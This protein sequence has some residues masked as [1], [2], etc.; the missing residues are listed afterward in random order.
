MPVLIILKE[1]G[2]SDLS[3]ELL[4][5][6]E[7]FLAKANECQTLLRLLW[8]INKSDCLSE[9]RQMIKNYLTGCG[10]VSLKDKIK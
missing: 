8:E 5:A 7:D 1:L 6:R 3:Q 4:Q 2:M 9:I 10:E